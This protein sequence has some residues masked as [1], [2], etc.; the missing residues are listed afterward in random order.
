MMQEFTFEERDKLR[1]QYKAYEQRIIA[2]EVTDVYALWPYNW[3]AYMSPIERNF[4]SWMRDH[5]MRGYWPQYPCG[6][7]FMDFASPS[8]KICIELDGKEFHQDKA[9]DKIRED[10][11]REQGY[12]VI[13]LTGKESYDLING[14]GSDEYDVDGYEQWFEHPLSVQLKQI[15]RR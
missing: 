8:A 1:A 12:K 10:Y 11:I 2:L 9:K 6:K 15:L 5:D 7:Y 3:L 4:F 14:D 13:R